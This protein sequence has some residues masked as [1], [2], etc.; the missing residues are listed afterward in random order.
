VR[1]G[2][3]MNFEHGVESSIAA[4]QRQIDLAVKAEQAG[5]DELWVSE[6]HFSTFTQSASVLPIMAHLAGRTSR[7][8]IGSAAILPPLHDPIRLAEDLATVD[9]LSSGRLNLGLAR[10][11]PFPTQY[12]HFHVEPETARE[13]SDEAATFL[14]QLLADENVSFHGRWHQCEGLTTLPR[15]VQ[16]KLPVWIASATTTNV[17]AAGQR[18]FGLMAGHAWSPSFISQLGKIYCEASRANVPDFVVLRTV[19]VADTDAAALKA[20]IPAL[21]HFYEQMRRHS[22]SSQT[23]EPISLEKSLSAAIIGSPQTCRRKLGE[24]QAAAPVSSIVMK[25]ACLDPVMA[26]EVMQ[27][28]CSEVAPP[29]GARPACSNAGPSG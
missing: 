3:F 5:L 10:G 27:R 12:Q 13:R 28:F 4:F 1:L 6:H 14:L 9:I 7:I 21:R 20:A 26:L 19:C 11:G 22:N 25:I 2:L 18:G 15:L 17:M 8:R 29:W 24:L 16:S 23:S